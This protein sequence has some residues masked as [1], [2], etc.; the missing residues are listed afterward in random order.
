V[1][2]KLTMSLAGPLYKIEKPRSLE[3]KAYL[4]LKQAIISGAVLPGA[5]ITETK[6]AQ[7]MGV[8]RTPIR[9]AL[10]RVEQEGF[11]TSL[12]SKGYQ[13]VEMSPQDLRDMYD[14]REI[15]ECHLIHETAKQ[16][17]PEDLAEMESALQAANE[18]FDKGDYAGFVENSRAFHH[19]FDRKYGNRRVSEVLATL[20]E[21]VYRF[22]ILHLKS[23]EVTPT[24]VP[25]VF[26][27]HRF[28][29]KAIRE[30]DIEAAIC[31]TREHTKIYAQLLRE[32]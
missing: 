11:I 21:Q 22:W 7:E 20:D 28:I 2:K 5:L 27:D 15:L 12:P 4:Q 6:L 3:E 16:L 8:S 9:K 17:T 1:I 13:L 25:A 18:C 23:G 32:E 19:T 29:L 26:N 24:T 14:L 30:G 10:V 31:R